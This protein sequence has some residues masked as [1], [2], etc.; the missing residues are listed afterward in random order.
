MFYIH[1]V[2]YVRTN[3]LL[4]TIEMYRFREVMYHFFPRVFNNLYRD[5]LTEC[6][7]ACN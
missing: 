7:Q 4:N 5:M 2:L 1:S 6:W 3:F